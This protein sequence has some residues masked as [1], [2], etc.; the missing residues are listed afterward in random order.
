MITGCSLVQSKETIFLQKAQGHATQD[1]VKRQLGTPR[2]MTTSPSGEPIWIYQIWTWQPG[3]YRVT[4]PGMWCE[5]YRLIFDQHAILSYWTIQS[6][7][8]GGESF[9]DRCLPEIRSPFS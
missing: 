1:E 2:T 5:E 4:A 7:F 6:H 3:D 9:P 8:H